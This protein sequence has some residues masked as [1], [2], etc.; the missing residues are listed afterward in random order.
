M[1]LNEKQ[2]N[3]VLCVTAFVAEKVF[4]FLFFDCFLL[5]PCTTEQRRAYH[6]WYAYHSLINPDI[7]CNKNRKTQ[8]T[9]TPLHSTD[10]FFISIIF[11]FSYFIDLYV[12]T[13]K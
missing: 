8:Y 1:H 9:C 3:E 12:R 6:W 2:L 5:R 7:G 13:L 10:I 4:M 11:N